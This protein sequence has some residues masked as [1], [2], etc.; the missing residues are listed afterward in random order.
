MKYLALPGRQKLP[1]RLMAVA[2]MALLG[3]E[4]PPPDR[5]SG[6]E[7]IADDLSA[8][9]AVSVGAGSPLADSTI[10]DLT[11]ASVD[12][13]HWGRFGINADRKSGVPVV[14]GPYS[15]L[16]TN[17]LIAQHQP[18]A[19]PLYKWTD[20]TPQASAQTRTG[21]ATPTVGQGM[22]FDIALPSTP[23]TLTLYLTLMNAQATVLTSAPLLGTSVWGGPTRVTWAVPIKLF[24]ATPKTITI[25][26][27][28]DGLSA[29]SGLVSLNAAKLTV[30]PADT[31]LTW[32]SS[33]FESVIPANIPQPPLY[34]TSGN[35]DTPRQVVGTQLRFPGTFTSS[36]GIYGYELWRDS[37]KVSEAIGAHPAWVQS[38]PGVFDFNE[39]AID[40]FGKRAAANSSLA[41]IWG[42]AAN[43][44]AMAIPDLGCVDYPLNMS[45]PAVTTH[46]TLMDV[47]FTIDHTYLSDLDVSLV[48]PLG[49]SALLASRLGGTS[50]AGYQATRILSDGAVANQLAT[51]SPPY[52]Q[53]FNPVQRMEA[54]HGA[55]MTGL[56][57]LRVCD[58]AGLDV[59]TIRWARLY[60]LAE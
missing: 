22:K 20:G 6:V 17:G 33:G 13:V 50:S 7:T 3:C 29:S 55:P 30:A 4:G 32:V 54:L 9:G 43:N 26:V 45:N 23:H 10:I 46:S 21:I 37:T 34:V 51:F 41:M 52:S 58:R 31:T 44:T 18:G 8:T 39:V 53:A 25:T 19:G 27:R 11:D 57:L 59:G 12:W 28:L 35:V 1:L 60:V 38:F 49:T 47:S 16:Q 36:A 42:W 5:G 2:A 14:I 24:S 48:S 40:N 56:W 15:R